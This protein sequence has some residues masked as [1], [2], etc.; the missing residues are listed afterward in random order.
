MGFLSGKAFSG[1]KEYYFSDLT[2]IQFK[3][4]SIWVNGFLYFE[5]PGGNNNENSFVIVKGVT[6]TDECQKA[7]EFIKEKIAECKKQKNTSVSQHS[8]ADELKKFK[9]LLDC[10]AITQ[11][12]F[13]KKKKQLLD[14]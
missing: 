3:Q 9:E 7:Y 11:E 13:D 2:S 14:L 12:E 8:P 10:G 1:S 4:A 6:D 5:Y